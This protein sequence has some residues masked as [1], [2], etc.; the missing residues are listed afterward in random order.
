[1]QRK[2]WNVLLS[3]AYKELP[4]LDVQMHEIRVRDLM[5]EVGF[6]SKNI[7]YLKDALEK[8]VTTKLTWNI[9]DEKGKQEWGVSAALAS[10]SISSGICTYSYSAHLRKKLYN[11]EMYAPIPLGVLRR[12]SSGHTIALYENGLRY[13]NI[14]ETPWLELSVFK[15]LLGVGNNLSYLDFKVLN[16]AVIK[17]AV[18]EVNTVSDI[19]LSVELRREHRKVTSI[20]FRVESIRQE[21]LPM[22]STDDFNRE[23]LARL[24]D[25]F[26]LSEKQSKE[27]L[28]THSEEKVTSVMDYVEQRYKD[29]KIGV[30]KIAPYFINTLPKF[31]K[32]NTVSSIDRQKKE[33]VVKAAE[34]A[35]LDSKKQ[36]LLDQFKALRDAS[37]EQYIDTQPEAVM[38]GLLAEF[39]TMLQQ[40][41]QFVYQTYKRSGI[42]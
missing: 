3:S 2:L 42:T 19:N 13:K 18:L 35:E 7:Q 39:S 28:A 29:G 15:D 36:A 14:G 21:S 32:V 22:E 41:N 37:I 8:L 10:A 17:P 38:N 23:I 27:I 24:L 26:C 33:R 9:L 16:R 11:P 6:D 31:D 4:N 25:T 5:N 30:G 1:M 12:F 34:I 20:K 40:Q